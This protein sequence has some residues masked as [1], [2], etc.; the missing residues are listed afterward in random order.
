MA[1][2]KRAER[3]PAANGNGGSAAGVRQCQ[4]IRLDAATRALQR[5]DDRSIA[6]IA[7]RCGFSSQSH[8]TTL[9]RRHLGTTPGAYLRTVRLHQVHAQLR[10]AA[11]EGRAVP[12]YEMAYRYGFFHLG[13]FSAYYTAQFGEPPSATLKRR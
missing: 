12:L 5:Q 3:P 10:A 13:R 11:R 2:G 6:E 9:M 8:L 4:R 1:A 7:D